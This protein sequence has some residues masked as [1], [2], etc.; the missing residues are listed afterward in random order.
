MP[1]IECEEDVIDGNKTEFYFTEKTK[2]LLSLAL[3][4]DNSRFQLDQI[5][6]KDEEWSLYVMK[7]SSSNKGTLFR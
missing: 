1:R 4:I 2:T 3:N 6:R 7:Y 5:P